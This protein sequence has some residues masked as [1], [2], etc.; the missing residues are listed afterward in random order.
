MPVVEMTSNGCEMMGMRDK[1]YNLTKWCVNNNLSLKIKKI[2]ELLV[3]PRQHQK[4]A[5]AT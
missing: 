3:D 2:K 5:H 4:G 1:I